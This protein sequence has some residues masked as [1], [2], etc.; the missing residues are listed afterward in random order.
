MEKDNI[1]KYFERARIQQYKSD[2]GF[3][4]LVESVDDNMYIIPRYQR[5]YRWKKSR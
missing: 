5:K 3:R 4:T 1:K 2:I